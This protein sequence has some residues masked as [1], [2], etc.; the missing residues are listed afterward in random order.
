MIGVGMAHGRGK[1]DVAKSAVAASVCLDSGCMR[2]SHSCFLQKR[3]DIISEAV[4]KDIIKVS[5]EHYHIENQRNP[6]R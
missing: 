6:E 4:M 2:L 5:M 1:A 3:S